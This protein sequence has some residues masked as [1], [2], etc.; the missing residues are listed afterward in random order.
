MEVAVKVYKGAITSDGIADDEIR[1]RQQNFYGK[2]C[3]K[4]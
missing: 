4:I 3:Y 2:L 1:V